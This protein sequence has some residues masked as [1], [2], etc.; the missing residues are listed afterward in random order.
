M[1]DFKENLYSDNLH[2]YDYDELVKEQMQESFIKQDKGNK[3]HKDFENV[4]TNPYTGFH[5]WF[6]D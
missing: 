3:L 2:N 5:R 1:D 4:L 6:I